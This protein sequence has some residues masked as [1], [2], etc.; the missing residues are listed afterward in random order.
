VRRAPLLSLL[1]VPILLAGCGSGGSH[2]KSTASA[3]RA[4]SGGGQAASSA[5]SVALPAVQERSV[6]RKASLDVTVKDTAAAADKAAALAETSGG[7]VDSDRR[8][9]AGK[10]SATLVLRVPPA[11]LQRTMT[12]LGKLGKES[13]RQVT[14]QDVTDSAVD[15]A[16]R[17]AT[18]RASVARV[19]VLLARADSITDITR[20]EGELTRREADLESLLARSKALSAQVDLATLTLNLSGTASTKAAAPG[21]SAGFTDG[22]GGGWRALTGTARVLAVVAGTL[23]P[24]SPLLLLALAGRVLWRRRAVGTS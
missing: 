6:V 4:V 16:S 5:R 3:P 8:S 12:E 9:Q 18:Q 13:D 2:S 10:G 15:L 23:L 14:D 22:L 24:F 20:V 7:R 17:I 19:R 1:V 21:D 11:A